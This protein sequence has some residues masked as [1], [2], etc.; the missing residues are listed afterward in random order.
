MERNNNSFYIKKGD[1]DRCE[2][3]R[4][5]ALG[6]TAYKILANIILEKIKPY[7]EKI[8]GDY[9]NGFRDERSVIDNIIVLKIINDNFLE[10]NRNVQYLLIYFKKA[11]GS[12]H[13]DMLRKCMEELKIPKENNRYV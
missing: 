8:T 6:N 12:I 4:R 11:Y 7:I 5:I 2:N 10:Y 1:R 13:R 9:Q 3:Y